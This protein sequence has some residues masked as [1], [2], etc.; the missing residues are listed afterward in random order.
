MPELSPLLWLAVLLIALL[1][2]FVKG[3]VGFALPMVLI[4]GLGSFL[5]PETAIAGLLLPTLATNAFQAFR[6]G[7]SA[8]LASARHHWRFV[9]VAMVM[10]AL[11]AQLV[12]ALSAQTLFLIIGVPVTFFAF[13]QLAGIRLQIAAGR[14]RVAEF[15]LALAA[16]F[17]GGL[18]GIWG[19]PTVLYLTALDTPKVEHMRVQGVVY[20]FGSV[21]LTI[22]HLRSGLLDAQTGTFSALLLLPILAGLVAGVY[23]Q[24]RLDQE[25]F[26]RLTLVVLALA[27]LNLVRRG[28]AL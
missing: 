9:L 28:L 14:R 19:P 10:I 23:V 15:G 27:G 4:S 17:A 12:V 26:R 13:I 21:V 16:G 3:V 11:T 8:A 2:G 24:D 7:L 1:A 22:A 18:S 5:P 20:G 25:R 6:N